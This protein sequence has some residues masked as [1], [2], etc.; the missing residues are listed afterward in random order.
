M[1][2]TERLLNLVAFFLDTKK[3]MSLD[4]IRDT[5]PD[6]YTGTDDA[7]Q[8]KFERDKAELHE[9]GVPLRFVPARDDDEGGYLLDREA[10]YLPEP[11]FTADELAVLYA[12]GSAALASGAFPGRQELA[13]ALRK[14]G[15]FAN[16]PLPTTQVRLELGDS[17]ELPQRLET[18]WEAI[19]A[20]KA[21]DLEYFSPRTKTVTSR[22][23]DPWGL[24][25]RR[26]VWNLVGYCHLRK[27][28]RTF[29][30]HRIRRAEMNQSKPKQADFTVPAD[31]VL[32]Q[33]VASWPWH[34]R[35]HEPVEV[36]LALTPEFAALASQL[37]G[38]E[39]VKSEA[40]V[41]ATHLEPLLHQ[42]LSLGKGA[43]VVSPESARSEVK[44]LAQKVL[45]AHGGAA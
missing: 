35:I 10:Y 5:F 9:L 38:V 31:F 2:R 32:D 22:R 15:F 16:T 3:P 44:T 27:E 13:H 18:L 14:V 7:S 25:L 42:V 4:E 30:V 8:R 34:H 36:T 1:D 6:D 40:R 26:G 39:A 41:K 29:Y 28:L 43:R 19:G 37:F 45:D 20:R 17:K 33:H 11:G 23:V 21:L 12:T 24:A